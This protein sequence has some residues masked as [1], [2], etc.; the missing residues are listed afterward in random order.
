M[1]DTIRANQDNVEEPILADNAEQINY[2]PDPT[3]ILQPT[4]LIPAN[5]G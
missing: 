3:E 1:T 5:E 2:E 4:E